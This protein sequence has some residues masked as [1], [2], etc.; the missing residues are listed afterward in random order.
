MAIIR[1][2]HCQLLLL[3]GDSPDNTCPGCGRALDQRSPPRP[4][5]LGGQPHSAGAPPRWPPPGRRAGAART[6]LLALLLA[7]GFAA[8]TGYVAYCGMHPFQLPDAFQGPPRADAARLGAVLEAGLSWAMRVCGLVV[9]LL[10]VALA[11]GGTSPG[12]VLR[13]T[14]LALAGAILITQ[15]WVAVVALAGVGVAAA[16]AAWREF[17]PGGRA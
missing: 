15:H 9:T 5:S 16:G 13:S 2:P 14:A 8:L 11:V 17:A 12:Q 6:L 10:A 7:V 1:C 3:P 4:A